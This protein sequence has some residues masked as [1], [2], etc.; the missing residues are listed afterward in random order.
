[1]P[2][3]TAGFRGERNKPPS[4][5]KENKQEKERLMSS[6]PGMQPGVG[7]GGQWETNCC[8]GIPP[9]DGRGKSTPPAI[10]IFSGHPLLEHSRIPANQSR[11]T[12]SL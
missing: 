5:T 8:G 2:A 9:V 3:E 4:I 1:M 11:E 7:G 10:F 6:S 12:G